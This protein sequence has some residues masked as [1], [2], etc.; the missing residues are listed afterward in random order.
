V[1]TIYSSIILY[2]VSVEEVSSGGDGSY[3]TPSAAA[4]AQLV[5]GWNYCIIG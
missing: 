5:G 3:V 2:S 4:Y 1:F